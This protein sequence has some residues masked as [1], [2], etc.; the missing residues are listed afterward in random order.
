MSWSELNATAAEEAKGT[1]LSRRAKVLFICAR[2]AELANQAMFL[3][4][5]A[6]EKRH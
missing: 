2:V 5:I 4:K 1:Y 3:P 6:V